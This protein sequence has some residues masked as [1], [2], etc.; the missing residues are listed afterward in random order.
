MPHLRIMQRELGAAHQER[1]NLQV[2]Q[3]RAANGKDSHSEAM[4]HL[5]EFGLRAPERKGAAK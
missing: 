3:M 1:R 5:L 4:R 2:M